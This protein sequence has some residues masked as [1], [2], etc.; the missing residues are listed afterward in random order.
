MAARLSKLD[1][2][3]FKIH[4]IANACWA[5]RCP[6]CGEEF[7]ATDVSVSQVG[8]FNAIQRHIDRSHGN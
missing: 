4:P 5:G 1:K 2:E 6:I 8:V 7:E 3:R